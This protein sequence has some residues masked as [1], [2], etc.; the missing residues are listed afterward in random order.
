MFPGGPGADQIVGASRTTS[1]TLYTLAAGTTLTA[2][3]LLNATIGA[4]GTCAPTV[5]VNGTNSAPAA[6]T[7]IARLN[8]TG[9]NLTAAADSVPFEILVKAPPE[10]A[11]TLDFTAGAN[12]ASSAT[13]SGWTFT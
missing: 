3:I 11:V 5:T 13:I 9:L 2:N 7:V 10:N 12:G 6:G 8:L 1:G 4:A